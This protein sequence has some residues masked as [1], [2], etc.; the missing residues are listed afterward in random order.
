MI[1]SGNPLA[2][3]AIQDAMKNDSNLIVTVPYSVADA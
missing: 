3:T 1:F 2:K